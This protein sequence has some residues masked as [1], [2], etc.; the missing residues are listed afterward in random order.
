[1]QSHLDPS[2]RKITPPEK[3]VINSLLTPPDSRTKSS[4]RVEKILHL[5]KERKSGR[6]SS[7]PA[8]Q[9]FKLHIDEY[10][11]LLD[12]LQKDEALWGFVEDKVR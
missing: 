2:A 7:I 10:I 9:T 11:E 6:F 12:Y 3:L 8:W 4:E 5:L 1:M